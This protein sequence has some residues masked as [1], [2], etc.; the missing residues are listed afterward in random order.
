M[1]LDK[2]C[3]ICG[4]GF[5]TASIGI[6]LPKCQEKYLARMSVAP[7]GERRPLPQMPP[8]YEAQVLGIRRSGTATASY[9]DSSGGSGGYSK[10]INGPTSSG[11]Y[12][13]DSAAPV[14]GAGARRSSNGGGYSQASASSP[15]ASFFVGSPCRV[16]GRNF[17]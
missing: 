3:Y 14:R 13:H 8:G 15:P 6:H 9:H 10:N 2:I 7:P 17:A 1:P 11:H 4:R 5:G 12:D 16:C